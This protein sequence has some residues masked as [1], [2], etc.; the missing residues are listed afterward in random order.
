[1]SPLEK[2]LGF[3][4]LLEASTCHFAADVFDPISARMAADLGFSVGMLAGSVA[5]LAVLGA[6]DLTLLTMTELA[7][8]VRRICRASDLPLMVDADHGYGN[9]LNVRR[10]VEELE[11]AGLAALTIEDTALPAP[12][13]G[14]DKSLISPD[15]GERKIRAGVSA[16]SDSRLVIIART[17]AASIAG[18][19]EAIDR[20]KRYEGAGADALFFSGIRSEDQ[21]STLRERL[22]LPILLGA[23]PPIL[24]DR[25]ALAAFGVRICLQGHRPF[26]SAMRACY[27]ALAALAGG[28]PPE[29]IQG[30][31]ADVLARVTRRADYERWTAEYLRPLIPRQ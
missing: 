9:A 4:K 14:D 29:A 7:E 28:A 31:A 5:S 15:E 30:P 20:A 24:A 16:R 12:F 18:I 26:F 27:E 1:M 6:P 17:A 25:E 13:G 3:R 23:V 21:L 22:N 19:D 2:R 11:A 10:T 8:L